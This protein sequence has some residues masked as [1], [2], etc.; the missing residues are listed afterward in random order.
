MTLFIDV[1]LKEY[2]QK[3]VEVSDNGTGVESKNFQSLSML[4]FQY[5]I[6]I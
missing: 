5:T 1:K 6:S 2:G 4:D 3:S